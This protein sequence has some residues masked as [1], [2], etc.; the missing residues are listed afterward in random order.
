MVFF[1]MGLSFEI[2]SG[3][4]MFLGVQWYVLFNVLAGALRIPL[5][6]K[7]ALDL[8]EASRVNVWRRLY[9]PSIFPA[10]V[11]GW[12]TAAGGAWN[13]SIVAEVLTFRGTEL[14]T[15]GLGAT[16]TAA[17]TAGDFPLMAASLTVMVVVVVFLNRTLWAKLYRSSQTRF[18]MDLA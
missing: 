10:L 5:E 9:I 11:T 17:E 4:L 2:V 18:R 3:L 1:K 15:A 8:M 12:V 13:A 7:Y 6:L 16:I 14:K